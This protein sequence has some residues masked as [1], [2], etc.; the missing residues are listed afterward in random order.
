MNFT[1]YRIGLLWSAIFAVILIMIPQLQELQIE[2]VASASSIVP[3]V[4]TVPAILIREGSISKNAT[5]VSTLVDSQVPSALANDIAG[6][7]RPVFDL[8]RI[9]AGNR[10][11]IETQLDGALVAFEYTIDD[12]RTLKVFRS[13]SLDASPFEYNARIDTI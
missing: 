6:Q 3:S 4:P 1:G 5:L 8:R 2:S 10:Y 11:H 9:H 12:E 7:I 13:A